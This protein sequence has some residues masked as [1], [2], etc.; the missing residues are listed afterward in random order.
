MATTSVTPATHSAPEGQVAARLAALVYGAVV[1][2][3]F[4][5]TFVV[6]VVFVT[7]LEVGLGTRTLP[8][9]DGTGGAPHPVTWSAVLLDST[10]VGLFAL[11]HSG[12]ARAS[13]KRRWV[14]VLPRRIER[15]T[16]VLASSTCLGLLIVWWRPMG[17]TLWDVTGQPGRVLLLAVGSAGWVLV[18]LSTF[19]IDHLHLVGLRQVLDGWRGLTDELPRFVTPLLYR[20]VRHPLYVGFLVA[21]WVTPRMTLG[22]LLFA[23][24]TTA[25]VL[26]G[27]RLEERDLVAVFGDTYRAYRERTRM[28]VPI[29]RRRG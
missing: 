13:F 2:L 7:G 11:Q 23:G 12:M 18:L 3:L 28:L 15:S 17:P 19:L 27:T 14:R 10:L 8:T 25:Y 26:V 20:L 16:F 9:L 4:L 29:P 22:H 6:A 5:A 21:F 1:Y 24:T